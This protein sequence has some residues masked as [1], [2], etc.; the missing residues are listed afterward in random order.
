MKICFKRNK[1]VKRGHTVIQIFRPWLP[2]CIDSLPYLQ[3]Q[4]LNKSGDIHLRNYAVGVIATRRR[5]C[6]WELTQPHKGDHTWSSDQNLYS[7][8]HRLFPLHVIMKLIALLYFRSVCQHMKV[9]K[10]WD[11]WVWEKIPMSVN[12][13][14]GFTIEISARFVRMV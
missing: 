2:L 14:T 12:D 13:L 8:P 9:N 7:A 6:L 10:M 3:H 11:L 4:N 1:K 5:L